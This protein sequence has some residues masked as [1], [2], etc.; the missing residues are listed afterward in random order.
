MDGATDGITVLF[1][2]WTLIYHL[3]L[4]IRPPT[5]ALLVV[6]LLGT[7]ALG[8]LYGA[9]RAWWDAP[10]RPPRRTRP[11]APPR[12][13]AV[14]AAVAGVAAGTAAGLHSSG[15]PLVGAWAPG[16][17]SAAASAAWVL[18]RARAGAPDDRAGARP[19]PAGTRPAGGR[20][21]PS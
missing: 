4:L 11:A 13:L 8:A 5:S 12:A 21:S 16:I 18:R 10:A 3:G 14:V 6:W 2:A 9:R 1:A 19:A 15:V 17:V 20:R 7:G